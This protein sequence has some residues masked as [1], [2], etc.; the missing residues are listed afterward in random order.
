MNEIRALATAVFG[1]A[2]HSAGSGLDDPLW[3]TCE[4][5]GFARLT[6]PEK[7]GGSGATF[8][9]AGEMLSAAGRFAARVPLAET[10]LAAWLLHAAGLDAPAGPLAVVVAQDLEVVGGRANGTLSRVPWGRAVSGIAVSMEGRVVLVDPSAVGAFLTEGANIAEEPRDGLSLD[11]AVV[12]V[13][14]V[15]PAVSLEV[16]LRA[17]LARAALLAGAA[18]GALAM[19]VRYAGERE[20]FGRPIGSFQAI[21]QSLAL[22]AGEVASAQAGAEAAALQA[23]RFGIVDAGFAIA[24]A[25][26][27]CGEAAG[28][29]ARIAHQV[30]GAIGVTR[31][32]DLRRTTTRLW[33]WREE[34]EAEGGWAARIGTYTVD[35]GADGLWPLLVR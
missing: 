10:D 30:H 15:S 2:W 5:T 3:A 1:D 28:Q 31:E 9:D 7:A 12:A 19:A 4:R 8:A 23:D 35:R 24:V 17:A 20:Q 22:A 13:G 29:V 25:K 33:A 16:P 18:S 6:A 32:H 21:Q 14:G 27:R 26:S 11:R 34:D